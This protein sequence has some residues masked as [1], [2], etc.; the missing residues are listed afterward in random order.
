MPRLTLSVQW[1]LTLILGLLLG[2]LFQPVTKAPPPALT[3]PTMPVVVQT[4]SLAPFVT[5]PG[6]WLVR[7]TFFSEAAPKIIKVVSLDQARMTTLSLGNNQIQILNKNGQ[8]L[9]SQSFQVEFLTGDP[10]KPV[11]QKDMVFVLPVV[12]DAFQIVVQGPNGKAIYDF[13]NK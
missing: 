1:S 6:G 10:P 9:Y 5:L 2:H 12:K 7:I 13:P 8:I 11:T 4:S 3:T